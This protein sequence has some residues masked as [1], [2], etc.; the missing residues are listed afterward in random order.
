[1]RP[2]GQSF[3]ALASV[4][5]PMTVSASPLSVGLEQPWHGL[6][7]AALMFAH[8]PDVSVLTAVIS[9]ARSTPEGCTAAGMGLR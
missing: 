3:L 9:V 4:A 2:A 6:R 8:N 1:M 7:K 5:V